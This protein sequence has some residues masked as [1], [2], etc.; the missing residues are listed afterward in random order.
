[1]N[2]V[3]IFMPLRLN[4]KRVLNKNIREICGKPLF[5][6]TLEKITQL[7]VPVYIYTNWIN[8]IKSVL[9]DK[10]GIYEKRFPNL[11]LLERP[12]ELDSD[13]TKGID[14]YNAFAEQCQANIY[15]LV[16]CTSPFVKLETYKEALNAIVDDNFDSVYTVQRFQTFAHYDGCPLNF[17]GARP[18]TQ[19]INSVYIETSGIYC[20]KDW[21]LKTNSRSGGRE[22]KIVID[23]IESIDIDTNDD[24]EFAR[25]IAMYVNLNKEKGYAC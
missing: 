2:E 14:I 9:N 4:S 23:N 24:L 25:S 15:M 21:V 5:C 12:T 11:T 16:H 17:K 3:A 7:D 22:K 20:Y 10:Y 1:M 6:W 18:K 13:D 19:D 8:E